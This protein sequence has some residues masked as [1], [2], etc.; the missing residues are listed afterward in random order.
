M[1]EIAEAIN[2]L[3]DVIEVIGFIILI[4]GLAFII[5]KQG[6]QPTRCNVIC[7]RKGFEQGAWYDIKCVRDVIKL[8]EA[9]GKSTKFERALLK[10]WSKY[11][12]YEK[13]NQQSWQIK[14]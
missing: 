4:L 13:A 2:R 6:V 12:G 5:F 14:F 1:I 8:K 3:T 10:S 7:Y 9:R 11:E